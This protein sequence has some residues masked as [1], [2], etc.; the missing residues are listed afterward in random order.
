MTLLRSKFHLLYIAKLVYILEKFTAKDKVALLIG[1]GEYLCEKKLSAPPHDILRIG[2]ELKR[3]N[4]KTLICKDLTKANMEN[5]LSLFY[6][7][8]VE[9]GVYG[10]SQSVRDEVI[11]HMDLLMG[12]YLYV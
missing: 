5:V 12:L 6:K 1:N 9:D 10:E 7:L 2:E 8:L 4:F 3:M 11:G